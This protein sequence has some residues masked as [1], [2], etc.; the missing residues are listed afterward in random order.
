MR[1]FALNAGV[2]RADIMTASKL[3]ADFLFQN[4]ELYR[5]KT[6]IDMGCGSG[7]QG[8]VAGIN[9]AESVIYSDISHK[10]ADNARE[11]AERFG[12]AGKSVVVQGDLFENVRKKADVMIFNHPFFAANPLEDEP[13][14]NSMLQ[15]PETLERFFREAGEHL[16]PGGIIVTTFFHFAGTANNPQIVGSR[17]GYAVEIE[18]PLEGQGMQS[19]SFSIYVLKPARVGMEGR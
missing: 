14:S 3:L 17:H 16:N 15:P 2:F 9:G 12:I 8:V 1:G 18:V 11:N 19:G 6:V 4:K 13:V 10:A 7:I 5:G